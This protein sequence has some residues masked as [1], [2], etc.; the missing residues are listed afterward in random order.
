M[1]SRWSVSFGDCENFCAAEA[2][3]DAAV[4]INSPNATVAI[5]T[6][7]GI[8]FLIIRLPPEYLLLA[9]IVCALVL[10]GRAHE[11]AI[12]LCPCFDSIFEVFP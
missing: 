7:R 3:L 5:A 9:D 6:I 11:F 8:R 12:R 10:A 2:P 4:E 1:I